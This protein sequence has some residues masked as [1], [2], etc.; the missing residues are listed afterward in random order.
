MLSHGDGVGYGFSR[1]Q[2]RFLSKRYIFPRSPVLLGPMIISDT[3][4]FN[5]LAILNSVSSRGTSPFISLLN[6]IVP[7][8]QSFAASSTPLHPLAA[9]ASH[10]AP[11]LTSAFTP[12]PAVCARHWGWGS[13]LLALP[14]RNHCLIF[15]RLLLRERNA[16]DVLGTIISKYSA[17]CKAVNRGLSTDPVGVCD[18]PAP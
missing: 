11:M 15:F 12:A 3:F 8:W 16:F 10:R 17:R 1:H 6:A 5:P 18:P 14:N 13:W 7:T 4:R 9:M 2:A